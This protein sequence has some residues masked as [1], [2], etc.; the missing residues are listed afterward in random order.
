M[1]KGGKKEKR[2]RREK[3]KERRKKR[4]TIR[5]EKQKK[6]GKTK[7]K[8]ERRRKNGKKKK[9]E[10]NKKK[11]KGKKKNNFWVWCWVS[12]GGSIGFGC[13]FLWVGGFAVFGLGSIDLTYFMERAAFTSGPSRIPFARLGSQMEVAQV[14]FRL[15]AW[16]AAASTSCR[17]LILRYRW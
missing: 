8:G 11:Q 7:R 16:E 3:K 9:K 15:P 13:F 5:R 4:K 6:G 2:K 14:G 12:A 10:I 17:D 1:E